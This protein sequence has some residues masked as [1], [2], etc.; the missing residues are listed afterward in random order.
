MNIE[1]DQIRREL[2]ASQED[3]RSA[4]KLW[5]EALQRV[6]GGGGA[7]AEIP[8]EAKAQLLGVPSPGRRH[9]FKLGGATVLGAVVLAACGDSNDEVG[10]TG[11]TAGGGSATT[12]TSGG[13][14]SNMD[15]VLLRTAS[16]LEVLAVET[17]D[18]AIA[19]GLVT[20]MAIADAAKLFRD[21]HDEHA[22]Q[23]QSAT[24]D[25]GGDA[26]TEANPFLKAE[27][28]DP[29]LAGL[30][31]ETDVVSFALVLEDGGGRD[32]RLRGG[33][34]EHARVPPG[35]HGDR[36]R[37]GEAHDRAA[38][39]ALAAAGARGVPPHRRAGARRGIDNVVTLGRTWAPRPT[40]L[41]GGRGARR[42]GG[43]VR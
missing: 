32:V 26:Y 9:L 1:R 30:K 20:T 19:S 15:L 35:D 28:V 39:R 31:N 24:T 8:V 14:N 5:R 27:V 4:M 33:R 11:T 36:R 40:P 17:Y 43:C 34:A 37:G 25:A 10:Q 29:A 13:G 2:R 22:K 6:F 38:E 41:G 12:G 16:S 42:L 21:Q 18:A 3:Q 23:L 7:A